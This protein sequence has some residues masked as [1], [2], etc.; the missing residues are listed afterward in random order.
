MCILIVWLPLLSFVI[1]SSL[2]RMIGVTGSHIVSI[3]L[4]SLSF[5]SL[6]FVGYEHLVSGDV[7]VSLFP[8]LSTGLLSSS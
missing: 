1:S 2:G 3:V 5:L 7:V 6:L 4:M 8:F